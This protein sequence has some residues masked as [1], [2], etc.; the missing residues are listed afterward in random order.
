MIIGL[1]KR[2]PKRGKRSRSI[3]A[4][5]K[6]KATVRGQHSRQN[7]NTNI[8]PGSQLIGDAQL[9]KRSPRLRSL[10]RSILQAQKDT[11]VEEIVSLSEKRDALRTKLAKEGTSLPFLDYGLIIK[12]NQVDLSNAL[13]VRNYHDL[14]REIGRLQ[15]DLSKMEFLLTPPKGRPREGIYDQALIEK[16]AEP[17]LSIRHLAVRY[18]PRY[19]P[20]RADAA[21][22][23]MAQGLRRASRRA[24]K[25]KAPSQ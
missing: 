11:L 7:Q 14:S 1:E 24:L 17:K 23:M 25:K 15:R 6:G 21:I 13:E 20:E 10:A 3:A 12:S 5:T 18:F 8:S 22:R 4:P 19:F 9:H 16:L 2:I